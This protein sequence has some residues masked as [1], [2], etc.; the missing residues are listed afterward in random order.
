MQKI[1]PFSVIFLSG[2]NGTRMGSDVPKQYLKIRH[3]LLALYSFGV[4]LSLPEVGEIIVVCQSGSRSGSAVNFLRKSGLNALNLEGGM[5]AWMRA[6][7]PV[8]R[9]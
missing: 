7:L 9:G 6:G 4:F 8:V 3:K 5:M 2:G 1:T